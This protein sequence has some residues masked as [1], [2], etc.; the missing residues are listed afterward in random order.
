MIIVSAGIRPRDELA[1]DA[2]IALGPRPAAWWS[3]ITSRTDPTRTS[4]PSAKSRSTEGV[5]Y[6]LVAPGYRDGGDAGRQEPLRGREAGPSQ[7]A[8]LSAK[9]KLCGADVATFGDPFQPADETRVLAFED[10]M[11][12]VYKRLV[13][14]KDSRRLL[15]GI[16]VGDTSSYGTLAPPR[17]ARRRR[18]SDSLEELGLIGA[19][20]RGGP[21]LPP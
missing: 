8:D 3:T 18:M 10:Q 14:H 9:L 16:L 7:E 5:I 11:R 6:G 1:R 12:G 17:P 15:G 19:P 13:V 4:S 2:G 20:A 21:G